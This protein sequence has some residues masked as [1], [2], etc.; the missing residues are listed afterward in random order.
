MVPVL[1]LIAFFA[2]S[3]ALYLVYEVSLGSVAAGLLAGPIV[4]AVVA[5]YEARTS[6]RALQRAAANDRTSET[7]HLIA[8]TNS[9]EQSVL[10]SADELCRGGNPQIPPKS[11]LAPQDTVD[12]VEAALAEL[13]FQMLS[14]LIRVHEESQSVVL[15]EV[16]RRLATREHA[17]VGKGLEAINEL[18]KLTDDPELLSK[19]FE[20]D[21]LVTRLRRRVESTAILGGQSLRSARRPISVTTVLR[22]AISE[23]VEYP[24]VAPA[25]GTVGTKLGLP[26]HVGPDLT[27]LLAELIENSCQCSDP[28]TR[29]IVRAQEVAAGL[30]IEVEDRAVPMHPELRAELNRL[31]RAPDEVDVSGQ[32]RAGQLG[33]LTAAKIAQRHGLSVVLQENMTGGTTALVVVPSR[34]LVAIQPPGSPSVPPARDQWPSSLPAAR[35]A[36]STQPIPTLARTAQELSPHTPGAYPGSAS[37]EPPTLPRRARGKAT[38]R[39]SEEVG[40]TSSVPANPGL[41]AAFRRGIQAGATSQQPPGGHG[42]PAQ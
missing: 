9:V 10:W 35:D 26:G 5:D 42:R 16:L 25:A 13:Q 6:A 22:G 20:I 28:A 3:T 32:V 37:G 14:S 15:L 34:L 40:P 31:L 41:A 4:V 18:E 8:I 7:A 21:H 30:A 24:R 29:V 36:G 38:Y 2:A 12:P 39:P 17:L 11:A 1:L 27:H 33:L 23:V 19:I